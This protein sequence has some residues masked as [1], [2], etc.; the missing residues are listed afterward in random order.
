LCGVYGA[1]GVAT[2]K[3]SPWITTSQV[4][5]LKRFC[6]I[7]GCSG[8]KAVIEYALTYLVAATFGLL[9]G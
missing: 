3:E 2:N 9:I 4:V 6:F 1:V 8:V 5:E 7:A